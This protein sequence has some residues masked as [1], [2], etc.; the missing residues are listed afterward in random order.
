MLEA[1]MSMRLVPVLLTAV[2]LLGPGPAEAAGGLGV[3]LLH[4]KGGTPQ[5]L[6]KLVAALTGAGF[7]AVAPELCWSRERLFDK[8][9]GDCLKEVDA[10][11]AALRTGGASGIVVGGAGQG[12][13]YAIDYGATHS[14]SS[15]VIAIGPSA[16]PAD[17]ARYPDFTAS[18]KAAQAAL[19]KRQGQ[20]S[21]PYVELVGDQPVTITTTAAIY[22]S[23][24]GPQS[25]VAT[26]RAIKAKALPKLQAPLLW[27]AGTDD[28]TQA[29]T[30][31]VFA[32]APANKLSAYVRV[33]ADHDGT[34]DASAAAIINWLKSLG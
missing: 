12:A 1:R 23:F 18:L 6:A 25:P 26:I 15:G 16:D 27:I 20:A 2:L 19:K 30:R 29:S 17:S 34:A 11:V 9:Y 13:V 5:Q 31:A 7:Q 4:D 33:G 32:A 21:A 22:L 28:L 24:H 10:A 3:V 14:G 8:A